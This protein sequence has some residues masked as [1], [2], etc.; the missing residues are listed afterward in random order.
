MNSEL[1]TKQEILAKYRDVID[2][3]D[4]AVLSSDTL[5]APETMHREGATLTYLGQIRSVYIWAKRSCGN[6][7]AVIIYIGGF[8]Q[9]VE[10]IN[11][12]SRIAYDEIASLVE[13]GQQYCS[14]PATEYKI[15]EAAPSYS[16][17]KDSPFL[18]PEYANYGLS[19]GPTSTTTTTTTTTST[20]TTTTAPPQPAAEINYMPI[21]PGSGLVPNSNQWTRWT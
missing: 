17:L 16:A 7:V 3:D 5:P 15:A 1:P 8:I 6:V 2:T 12:Y 13:L 10:Y 18:I 21:P 4:S 19:S 9:G 20:T 11:R 14:S